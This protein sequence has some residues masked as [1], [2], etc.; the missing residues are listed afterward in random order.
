MKTKRYLIPLIFVLFILILTFNSTYVLGQKVKILD[1]PYV[2]QRYDTP[3]EFVGAFSCAPT[4]AVMVLA[5]Y[6]ILEP[7]P[8]VLRDPSRHLSPYGKYVSREYTYSGKTFDEQKTI[9]DVCGKT[10]TGK[11]AWGYIWQDATDKN[12][13]GIKTNLLKYLEEHGM[14]TSFLE[15]PSRSEAEETVRREIDNGRPLI[16][17]NYLTGSGHYVVIVGY[18]TDS[19]DNFWYLVND[20]NGRRFHYRKEGNKCWGC[21]VE[22]DP[23]RENPECLQP[24]KYSYSELGLG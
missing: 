21:Y 18:K 4:S 8:I 3:P 20:P 1:V 16:A 24:V 7:D 14:R 5:Y 2:H 10:A 12:A 9:H 6:G 13:Y 11:G 15:S 17:R 22:E 23:K 19:K